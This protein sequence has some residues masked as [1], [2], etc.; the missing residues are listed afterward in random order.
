[1]INFAC[2]LSQSSKSI[3]FL[4]PSNSVYLILICKYTF[5]SDIAYFEWNI[6]SEAS[7]DFYSLTFA[8]FKHR[9]PNR[10]RG[11]Y[12]SY[13]LEEL[14]KYKNIY[15]EVILCPDSTISTLTNSFNR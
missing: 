2:R 8:A 11:I 9:P 5:R 3:N 6:I 10:H 4:P 1:M 14:E 15:E 12:E 7:I 13:R